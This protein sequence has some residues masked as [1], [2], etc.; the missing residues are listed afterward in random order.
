MSATSE[1][2]TAIDEYD[3]NSAGSKAT[4]SSIDEIC[5]GGIDSERESDIAKDDL[6]EAIDHI[7]NEEDFD[8]HDYTIDPDEN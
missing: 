2:T 6:K 4:R 5:K 7:E 8:E 3:I 1:E